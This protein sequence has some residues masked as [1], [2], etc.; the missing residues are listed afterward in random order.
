MEDKI[1]QI[2]TSIEQ[3]NNI[4][5]KKREI[6]VLIDFAS[7][8]MAKELH[9]GHL[10]STILGNAIANILSYLGYNI[11]R[12]SHVGDFGTPIGLVLA[13]ILLNKPNFLKDY[14]LEKLPL[15]SELSCF[16]ISAKVK[17]LK[18]KK[19]ENIA[20]YL[21]KLLQEVLSKKYSENYLFEIPNYSLKLTGENII[22]MWNIICEASRKG[23]DEIYQKLDIKV[24]ERGESFYATMLEDVINELKEK[25]ISK[26][27]D[28]AECIFLEDFKNPF[29]I[30]KSDGSYLYSTTDLAALKYRI[31]QKKKW[32]IYITDESQKIHFQQLFKVGE[33]AGW[34]IPNNSPP[35]ISDGVNTNTAK[36]SLNHLTFGVVKG[37]DNKKLSSRDG[38][39]FSLLQLL[40]KSVEEAEKIFEEMK[41]VNKK[42]ENIIK[43]V[44]YNAIKYFDLCHPRDYV[45]SFQEMLSFKGNTAVYLMY[46]Y[47]RIKTLKKYMK[48]EYIIKINHVIPKFITEEERILAL[49]ILQF[50]DIIE[51]IEHLLSPHFLCEYLYNLSW[52][53]H[54]FY[55]KCRIFNENDENITLS[56][57]QLAIATEKILKKGMELLGL[58]TVDSL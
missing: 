55:E 13:E 40:E 5:N 18:D 43:A 20:H 39:P 8:N 49:T 48:D 21:T 37:E 4:K 38:K 36:I 19:F 30:K 41:H 57:L 2:V 12:I 52:K 6:N 9:V 31:N 35:T 11:E 45:F 10:R 29:L 46:A 47:A 50:E 14:S 16:Y 51:I 23:F 58:K 44:A 3:I 15:P 42:D 1:H 28:N 25:K 26:L 27:S 17:S 54:S 32:I 53:F 34:Y 22:Y 56:R 24:Q 33:K 7:P